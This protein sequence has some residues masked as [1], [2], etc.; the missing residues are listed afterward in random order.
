[1]AKDDG[2]LV[3]SLKLAGKAVL[4]NLQTEEKSW[5]TFNSFLSDYF[6][7]ETK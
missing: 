5:L 4:F 1:M 6:W 2:F 7:E 3:K